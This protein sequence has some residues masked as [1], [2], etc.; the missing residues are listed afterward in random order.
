[1]LSKLPVIVPGECDFDKLHK[2]IEHLEDDQR[3]KCDV[4]WLSFD[5]LAQHALYGD[6]Y[7]RRCQA[8]TNYEEKK[9]QLEVEADEEHDWKC[10]VKEVIAA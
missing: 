8:K 10:T 4:A 3:H 6:S 7:Q 2:L 5:K 9:L 1:M